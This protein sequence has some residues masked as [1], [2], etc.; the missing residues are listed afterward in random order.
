ML[1]ILASKSEKKVIIIFP[2]F[3]VQI[4]FVLLRLLLIFAICIK[5]KIVI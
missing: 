4:K 3:I 2:V 1:T 5:L